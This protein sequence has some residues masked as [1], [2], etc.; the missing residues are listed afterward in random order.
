MSNENTQ[1]Q[2][3]QSN[4]EGTIIGFDC[5]ISY[6][7][8]DDTLEDE[9]LDVYISASGDIDEEAGVDSFGVDEADIFFFLGSDK[10]QLGDAGDF[11]IHSATPVHE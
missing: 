7:K 9:Q 6:Y 8:N 2:S 10:I 3:V 4:C 5:S 11:Y 1:E